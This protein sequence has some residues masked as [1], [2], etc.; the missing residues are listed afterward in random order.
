MQTSSPSDRS[1]PAQYSAKALPPDYILEPLSLQ[2]HFQETYFTLRLG[3]AILGLALP[4]LL[5]SVAW[6]RA[7]VGLQASMSAYYFAGNGI[8][9]DIF[10]GVLVAVGAFL[11][12]Y[13][14]FSRQEDIA[15]NFAGFF[16][17]AVAM[18]PM[19]WQCGT[20]CSP[21]SVHGTAAILFFACIAYVCL[22][23]AM[24]TVNLL[25]DSKRIDYYKARY[26]TIGT[27]MIISPLAALILNG[28]LQS[29]G[30]ESYAVFFIEA[31]AVWVFSAYWLIKS[32]EMRESS[33]E[34]R[35]AL[36]EVRRA[37]RHRRLLPDDAIIVPQ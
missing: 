34:K 20:N 4:I 22:A 36:G 30:R 1:T 33:A 37:K 35:A 17:V 14:G 15:L 5:V 8:V 6:L 24:D 26:K 29:K 3:I 10:V 16:A 11:I 2:K 12:L 18:F 25:D 23:R 31:F 7:R 28:A 19:E 13:R 9:R 21:V 27:L 32:K